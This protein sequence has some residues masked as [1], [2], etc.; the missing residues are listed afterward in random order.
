MALCRADLEIRRRKGRKS[1]NLFIPVGFN[2]P[3]SGI[4]RYGGTAINV[5]FATFICVS[6]P[7]KNLHYRTNRFCCTH[8]GAEQPRLEN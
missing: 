6:A 3:A 4:R 8:V 2:A 7:I 5:S 1:P